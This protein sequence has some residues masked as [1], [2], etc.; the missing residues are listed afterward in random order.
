MYAGRSNPL[1]S[2]KPSSPRTSPQNSNSL[3]SVHVPACV[4]DATPVLSRDTRAGGVAPPRSHLPPVVVPSV[5]VSTGGVN[6][7][8]VCSPMASVATSSEHTDLRDFQSIA[9]S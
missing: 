2:L 9:D 3:G 4:R 8:T 1:A 6:T 7:R 5:L